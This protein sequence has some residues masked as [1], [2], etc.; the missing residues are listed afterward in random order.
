MSSTSASSTEDVGGKSS[1]DVALR[2]AHLAANQVPGDVPNQAIELVRL[3]LDLNQIK[4]DLNSHRFIFKF[5]N[6]NR[7]MNNSFKVL[8]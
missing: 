8:F 4:L 1:E 2:A 3:H 6:L 7:Q 5:T